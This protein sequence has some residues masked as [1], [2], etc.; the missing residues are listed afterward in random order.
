MLPELWVLG[1]RLLSITKDRAVAC[2]TCGFRVLQPVREFK[3]TTLGL[4]DD[5]RFPGRCI[6]ALN[7]H[8]E[9]FFRLDEATARMFMD[10]AREAARAIRQ[11]VGAGRINFAILGNKEPHVHAHLIPRGGPLDKPLDRTPWESQIPTR[12]LE[13][14]ERATILDKLRVAT[15]HVDA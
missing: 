8:A 5:A 3:G 12:R 2:S 11:A 13:P 10:E 9:D 14:I 4:Y 6:L 1:F 7:V 15:Q